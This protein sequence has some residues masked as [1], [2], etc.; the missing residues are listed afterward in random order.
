ML[1]SAV[2]VTLINTAIQEP[3]YRGVCVCEFSGSVGCSE[4]YCHEYLAALHRWLCGSQ[5]VLLPVL[6]P[7]LVTI[8]I[9]KRCWCVWACFSSV[10]L[11]TCNKELPYFCLGSWLACLLRCCGILDITSTK[12]YSI[13]LLP[14]TTV[15]LYDLSTRTGNTAYSLRWWIIIITKTPFG[16]LNQ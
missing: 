4:R 1:I 14:L 12:Y 11:M 8:V 15:L 2:G 7:G 9:G 13:F 10:S 3:R 6:C 5:L 16:C